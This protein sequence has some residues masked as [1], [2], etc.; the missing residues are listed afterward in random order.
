MKKK[1]WLH[2]LILLVILAVMAYPLVWMIGISLDHRRYG[3]P[4]L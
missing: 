4:V 2:I 3:I 1:S